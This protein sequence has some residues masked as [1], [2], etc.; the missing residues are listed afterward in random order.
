MWLARHRHA[1]L[2]SCGWC[3][4]RPVQGIQVHQWQSHAARQLPGQGRFTGSGAAKDENALR[5]CKHGAHAATVARRQACTGEKKNLPQGQ[6]FLSARCPS[7][8][9]SEI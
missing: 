4:L 1:G 2:A 8:K 5:A 7:R 3:A 6:I 9:D